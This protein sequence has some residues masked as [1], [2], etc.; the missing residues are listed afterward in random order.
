MLVRLKSSRRDGKLSFDD[1]VRWFGA[2]LEPPS[3]FYFRH[4]EGRRVTERGATRGERAKS[5]EMSEEEIEKRLHTLFHQKWKSVKKAFM[6][7]KK[8]SEHFI[9][10]D[11]LKR[12]LVE[13]CG[14]AMSDARFDSLFKKIDVDGDGRINY[15]EFNDYIGLDISPCEALFFR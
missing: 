9:E 11:D 6:A 2:A 3:S 5:V 14:F 8:E 1:F 10:P 4:D 12:F 13:R 15:S 7:L